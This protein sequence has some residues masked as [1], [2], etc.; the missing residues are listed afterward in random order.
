[1][2]SP[3]IGR[4]VAGY[5]SEK[6]REHGATPRGVDWNSGDAQLVRFEQI[7]RICPSDGPYTVLDYGCGYGALAPFLLAKNPQMQY[8]GYDICEEMVE[9]GRRLFGADRRVGFTSDAAKLQPA[10]VAVASG[11]FSVK[12]DVAPQAWEPYM[13]QTIDSMAALGTRGF[14]FNALTMYSDA[15]RMRPDLYY[16]DPHRL[17]DYCRERFS[18]NVALLHDYGLYEFT[19]LVRKTA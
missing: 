5:Y 3:E 12:M 6:L 19:V 14:S 1:M 4:R 10:D 16:A 7:T 11:I 15:D 8:V 2:H 18:R 9:Q 13:F 17:F